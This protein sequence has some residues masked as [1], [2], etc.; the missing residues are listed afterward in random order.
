MDMVRQGTSKINSDQI[1]ASLEDKL[2]IRM[3]RFEKSLND[4][5]NSFV[6]P[7]AP[8]K[9]VEEQ[10]LAIS[11]NRNQNVSNQM[12]PPGFNKPNQQNNQSRY[13]GNNLNQ[14][15]NRQNNQGVVYQNRPQQALNYQAPAQQNTVTHRGNFLDK[16]PLECL[17]I[18]E[19]K[20][21]V[22]YSRSRTTDSRANTNASL[23]SSPSNSFDLQQIAASLEDKLDIRMNR[24]EKSLNDM[25]NSFVTPTA[26]LKA[27]KEVCVTCRANQNYNQC[28][29][30]QE[31]TKKTTDMELPST[32]DIQPPSVQVEVQEDKPI[33]KPSVVIQKAKAN[34]PYPLRLVKEKIREKDDILAAKFIEIFRD[35]HFELSFAD[36]LVHM[37]KF[38]PMFKKGKAIVNSPQPI[39][40]QEPSMVDDDEDTSK[41][42]EIDKLMALISLSFKKIYK[43]T[44]N[45]L[46]TSLN[47][48]RAHQDNS[49][50]IL[51][52]TGYESQMSGTVARARETVGSSMVQKS[53][54]QCYNCKEYGHVAR[55]CQKPKRAKDAAY[56][57]EK[58]L[59]CKQEEAGIQ[60][61]ADQA[62]WKDDTK[63]WKH[64]TCT[65][66]KFKRFLQILLTL[67]LSLTLSQN[68]SS[69]VLVVV[70]EY[71]CLCVWLFGGFRVF[72]VFGYPCYLL[73]TRYIG[74]FK[75]LAKVETVA[76]RL[77]LTE[78][79][80]RVHSTL[81]VSNLKKCLSDEPLAIPL[82]E[83]HVDN[84][85]N[86]IEE[87]VEVMDREVKRLK[88]S[89]IS[90]VKVRWNSR[91]GP[92]YTW[93]R[94]YQMQKKY[95]HLFTNSAPA[96]EVAS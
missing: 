43:P 79:L 95:P 25:K 53:G 24:F 54:I 74:P 88:Q 51:R 83:I 44:N 84:K 60:L 18:I 13:Q 78:Q 39:Y 90:I 10:P 8:I 20:S 85:L 92:E 80:S 68:K 14:N 9:A 50:R 23:S 12:R 2:D 63:N 15:Q 40:N 34:L 36:A 91:R 26:P 67:D 82:D 11:F 75:I 93:E 29:E 38:A 73:N 62:D 28:V 69:F 6:T 57:R 76:Y 45:N 4:M 81:Y 59:L 87:P 52:N 16:I 35:L 27:V 31:P 66:L 72:G 64:I 46:R 70:F 96:A 71:P 22:R 42:K 65:W 55:D 33:E 32:K 5:K 30:E 37:P 47:T 56:H 77:K 58:M 19:S 94:E 48:S 17:S 7:T 89:R 61:N 1:A 86:F 49:P 21:K 41:D 3:N